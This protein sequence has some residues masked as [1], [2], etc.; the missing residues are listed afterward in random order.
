MKVAIAAASP[1]P[2]VLDGLTKRYGT[3]APV[4]RDFSRRF[5][6]GTATALV[7]PNGSGKTTLLRLLTVEAYPTAGT[8]RYGDLDIHQHPYRWLAHVGQVYAEAGL[9]Q[10]LTAAELL[11]WIARERGQWE[12]DGPSRAG[13]LLDA[14]RLD[15]RRHALIGTYSSGMLQKTQLAAAL[16]A[17]P[18]VLLMDE[19]F[20]GLDTASTAAAVALVA[21]FRDAGGLVVLASHAA[22]LID[23]LADAVVDLAA[24]TP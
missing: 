14:V 11:E 10:Q 3:H 21:A 16:I 13:A 8:V 20:R 24:R 9:P 12:V 4:L 17:R 2:L 1:E 6:P 5:E 7:G 22:P 15:E 23:T 19:P 18:A